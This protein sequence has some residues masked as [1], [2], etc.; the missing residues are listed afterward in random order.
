MLCSTERSLDDM[1]SGITYPA[2]SFVK[3]IITSVWWACGV[4]S[5]MRSVLTGSYKTQTPEE[6]N[7]PVRRVVTVKGD[8]G[9]DVT[10]APKSRSVEGADFGRLLCF[11]SWEWSISDHIFLEA[12]ANNCNTWG[13]Q[14]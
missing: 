3:L 9:V 6:K 7:Q 8:G 12:S 4:P 2:F 5:R 1:K 13:L 10:G 14:F 11:S